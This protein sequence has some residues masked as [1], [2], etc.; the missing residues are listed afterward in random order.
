MVTY[1]GTMH[2]NAS[3][4]F[5]FLLDHLGTLVEIPVLSAQRDGLL[6]VQ[7]FVGRLG[8]LNVQL[9]PI[10][11]GFYLAMLILA[12]R[13]DVLDRPYILFK[14]TTI[15][16]CVI[17]CSAAAVLLL[18]YLFWTSVG[19]LRVDGLQGRYFIPIAPVVLLLIHGMW[20]SAPAGSKRRESG[21]MHRLLMLIVVLFSCGYTL[22]VLYLHYYVSIEIGRV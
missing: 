8:W 10:F 12:C 9:S 7:S 20:R 1:V 4:Q 11:V 2:V 6:I 15:T 22:V 19:G 5:H 16:A 18:N 13:P 3:Q 21:F 17:A 14:L